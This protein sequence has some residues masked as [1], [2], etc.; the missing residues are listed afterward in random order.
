MISP[1]Q[2]KLLLTAKSEEE[3][4]IAEE[5]LQQLKVPYIVKSVIS[6][7]QQL[8]QSLNGKAKLVYRVFVASKDYYRANLQVK[9]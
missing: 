4:R 1:F 7:D 9:K 2:R 5:Q 8:F 6:G 3:L